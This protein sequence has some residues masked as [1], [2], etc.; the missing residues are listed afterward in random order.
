MTREEAIEVLEEVKVM[1]EKNSKLN[2]TQGIIVF[3]NG[4]CIRIITAGE[5]VRSNR[6]NDDLMYAYNQDYCI[7]LG[8]SIKA[9]KADDQRD[10]EAAVEMTEYCDRYEPTYNPEDGSM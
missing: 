8:L 9:L 10:Y 2:N 5:S 3:R 4:S 1:D 7:A 6:A